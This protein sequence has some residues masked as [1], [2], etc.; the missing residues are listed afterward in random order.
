VGDS[1]I[2]ADCRQGAASYH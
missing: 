1:L 2:E